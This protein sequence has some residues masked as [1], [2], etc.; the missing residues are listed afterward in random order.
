M[1]NILYKGELMY[2][3]LSHEECAEVLSELSYEFYEGSEIDPN[4]LKLEEIVNG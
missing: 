4:E 2:T 3:G 1:F